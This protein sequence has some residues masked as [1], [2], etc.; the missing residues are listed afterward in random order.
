MPERKRLFG[1]CAYESNLSQMLRNST[2]NRFGCIQKWPRKPGPLIQSMIGAGRDVSTQTTTET[3]CLKPQIPKR[4]RS[5]LRTAI[6][7][8]LISRRS[9]EAIKRPSRVVE[10]ANPIAAVL[11][12]LVPFPGR[13]PIGHLVVC[14]Q[15][16]YTRYHRNR[17]VCIAAFWILHRSKTE[18]TAVLTRASTVHGV[19]FA[20]LG[21]GLGDTAHHGTKIKFASRHNSRN[22]IQ[23][24]A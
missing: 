19:V 1:S 4:G 3:A 5:P 23:L 10:G 15:S 14:C 7:A 12:I 22:D 11:D 18:L 2:A 21:P 24:L 20:I 8:E 6:R 16:M 9:I 13:R 17:F